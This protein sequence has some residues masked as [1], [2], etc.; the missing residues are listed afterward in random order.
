MINFNPGDPVVTVINGKLVHG[1]VVS[2]YPQI[3]TVIVVTEDK[4]YIKVPFDSISP[5]PEEPK[6]DGVTITAEEFTDIC[7]KILAEECDKL[8]KADK[9]LLIPTAIIMT[10]IYVKLFGEADNE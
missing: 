6:K 1:K 8:D 7:T 10:K 2:F 4:E 3:S 9:L 5:E